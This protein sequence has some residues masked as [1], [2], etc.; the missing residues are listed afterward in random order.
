LLGSEC[1]QSFTADTFAIGLCYL[2]LLTGLEPYEE[3]LKNVKCPAYLSK[4]L[5]EVWTGESNYSVIQEVMHS[6]DD[7]QDE[8]PYSVLYDTLYRYL[9]LTSNSPN[10]ASDFLN[11][12]QYNSKS[13][14]LKIVFALGL[15]E[16]SERLTR[17]V[18]DCRNQFEA[19]KREWSL[20]SGQ[21]RIIAA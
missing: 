21:N 10:F 4:R 1:V 5:T 12:D 2:H 11:N 17:D 15:K 14:W 18:R 9:V 6:L 16:T 13:I 19:D 7:C 20:R 8:N 3:I